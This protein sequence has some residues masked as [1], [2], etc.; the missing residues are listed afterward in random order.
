MTSEQK[1]QKTIVCFVNK[2]SGRI[3]NMSSEQKI[4]K[5]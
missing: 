5:L 1:I 2:L 3:Q 4:L